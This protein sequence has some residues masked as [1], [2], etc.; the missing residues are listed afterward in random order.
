MH[1]MSE[2]GTQLV[3][4]KVLV[5]VAIA[6]FD[7]HAVMAAPVA[8]KYDAVI[9]GATPSGIIAAVTASRHGLH[10]VLLEPSQHI[11]G[12]MAGG[13]S[14]TDRG[15]TETIGGIPNEFFARVGQHYGKPMVWGFEPH[16]ADQVF[17]DMLREAK[18]DV[19]T[20]MRLREKAGVRKN[21][22]RIV[23][24]AMEN[25]RTFA[26]KEFADCSYEGDLMA[27][28]GVSVTWGRESRSQYGESLAGV[29]PS[30]RWDLQFRTKVSPYGSEGKLLPLVSQLPRGE[31]GAGDKRIPSYNYRFCVTKD[32]ANQVPF[33]KPENYNPSRFDLLARYLPFLET[34]KGKP[35]D[36]HDVLLLEKLENNKWDANNM[37]AIST[38]Y[39]GMNW[40]YPTA[41][42]KEREAMALEHKLYDE[43]FFYFLS[44]DSRVPAQLQAEINEYGL[45][46]D[47]FTDTDHFP[48]QLYIREARRMLGEYIFTQHDVQDR[49]TQPDSVGMGSYQL[50]SHNIQRVPTEDGG[51]MN[52]GD[53]FVA[54]TPYEIP[55]R[56]LTPRRTEVENLLV[57]VCIS[58][59]HAAYGTIRQEPVYMILGQATGTAMVLAVQ[60]Q[61]AVQDIPVTELQSRLT[62]DHAA[63]HWTAPAK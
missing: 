52:E 9:Y 40:T 3:W 63:L 36:V 50:D 58:S 61:L 27:E 18:V 8:P 23:M 21:G 44:H 57:S 37:G 32:K 38:D 29:L 17:H 35:L 55:Y 10:V 14:F 31:Y 25:G 48:H 15:N 53:Y 45:A 22:T 47:E 54:V 13:L 6:L 30:Q 33:P 5:L 24:V 1:K 56:S 51:V 28:A 19:F 20:G 46:K 2:G 59:T 41:T 4:H 34:K 11:G 16:I 39:T 7:A 26:G 42:Y 60:K 43:A 49:N 12:M 62:E